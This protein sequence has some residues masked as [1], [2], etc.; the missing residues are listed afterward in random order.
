MHVHLANSTSKPRPFWLTAE[1]AAAALARH[2]E[3]RD[4]LRISVDDDLATLAQAL[5]TMHVLVTSGS[6][7]TDARFARQ[8]LREAAPNLQFIHLIDAGVEDVMP[9]DWLPPGMRLTNNSGVHAKKA[10]EFVMMALLAL[11]SRMPEIAWHQRHARWSPVFT[12]SIAG[13]TLAVIGLGDL[14]QAAVAAGQML[15]LRTIGVRRSRADVP[16]VERVYATDELH[17]ALSQADFI[18]IATPLTSETRGMLDRTAL[19]ATR[20]GAALINIGRAGVLD[21]GALVELLEQEH[22][23]GAWL[24]VLPEEP[25][26]A[27]SP[28]WSTA[29]LTITPHCGADDVESYMTVTMEL[30]LTNIARQLAG[31]PLLNVVDPLK[32]Y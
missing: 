7:I 27:S 6:V 4:T 19:R 18:V 3:L 30:A 13:K 1:L 12:S 31:Q 26:P 11:N 29:N 17:E 28:L 25:L 10:R 32:Q 15:G 22:L 2:P 20:R 23:S 16:G 24:D 14:G 9:L 8:Q 21:H 5:P